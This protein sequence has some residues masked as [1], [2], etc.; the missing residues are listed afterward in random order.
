MYAYSKEP[1]AHTMSSLKLDFNPSEV[2][3][4]ALAGA[5][6]AFALMKW[7]SSSQQRAWEYPLMSQSL[8]PRQTQR[9]RL[10]GVEPGTFGDFVGGG[11]NKGARPMS[12]ATALANRHGLGG[13]QFVGSQS[14]RLGGSMLGAF[15]PHRRIPDV[16]HP[17]TH[18]FMDTPDAFTPVPSSS[19]TSLPSADAPAVVAPAPGPPLAP[20]P[21][22]AP[23]PTPF[24]APTTVADVDVDVAPDTAVAPVAPDTDV[25]PDIAVAPVPLSVTPYQ[26]VGAVYIETR[27]GHIVQPRR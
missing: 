7:Q 25:A 1:T 24:V 18:Q 5:V 9:K 13:G 20:S 6:T 26:P 2:L 16:R 22:V 23:T 8:K 3:P 4:Y 12:T 14:T 15:L 11:A 21:F 17:R 10:V 19:Q 27:N